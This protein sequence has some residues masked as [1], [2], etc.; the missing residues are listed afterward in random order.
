MNLS[1]RWILQL[2][3]CVLLLQAQSISQALSPVEQRYEQLYDRLGYL[4][5]MRE[6]SFEV[7]RENQA[8]RDSVLPDWASRP[9]RGN[10][11]AVSADA[12][13]QETVA[14]ITFAEQN[15][16]E[17][18]DYFS[19]AIGAKVSKALNKPVGKLAPE[20]EMS[21]ER[22]LLLQRIEAALSYG[23][24][25]ASLQETINNSLMATQ[26][27]VRSPGMRPSELSAGML[28]V[29][30]ASPGV[31]DHYTRSAI[32]QM[33]SEVSD[34]EIRDFLG[35][36]ESEGGRR[37]L[38]S[39]SMAPAMAVAHSW[40]SS[41]RAVAAAVAAVNPSTPSRSTGSYAVPVG[42]GPG[43]AMLLPPEYQGLD[44]EDPRIPMKYRQAARQ[45]AQHASKQVDVEALVAQANALLL[46]GGASARDL[47]S[48]QEELQ[49]A[50]LTRP[51]EVELLVVLGRLQTRSSEKRLPRGSRKWLVDPDLIQQAG[52]TLERAVAA[53]PEHINA[54][55]A[56]GRVRFLLGDLQAAE[57]LFDKAELAGGAGNAWLVL[58]RADLAHERGELAVA[59]K[60]HGSVLE[61]PDADQNWRMLAFYSL[62][63]G[64][65]RKES[66][67]TIAPMLEHYLNEHPGSPIMRAWYADAILRV[68]E[69]PA[70]ARKQ[71]EAMGAE[72]DIGYARKTLA[73]ALVAQAYLIPLSP[74]RMLS[75][76][77]ERLI[78]LS[79]KYDDPFDTAAALAEHPRWSAALVTMYLAGIDVSELGTGWSGIQT[80]LGHGNYDVVRELI[81]LGVNVNRASPAPLLHW[82]IHAKQADLVRALLAKGA[83]PTMRDGYGRTAWEAIENDGTD[84][85]RAISEA[86]G[87]ERK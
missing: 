60:L 79:S 63:L 29:V 25:R 4:Q 44:P 3:L 7:H 26:F 84:A 14:Q 47:I 11:E 77:A 13:V 73:A 28:A 32:A 46:S 1:S 35:F 69:D 38:R 62:A 36:A 68:A 72:G 67:A 54:L 31:A 10:F 33:F 2:L 24:M 22:L 45:A 55:I 76:E 64:D 52:A 85:A 8:A 59:A 81:D 83:D 78:A 30:P 87:P 43:V 53:G 16:Q 74:E 27:L 65:A 9:D 48:M 51:R 71:I 39:A 18:E 42:P 80:A 70:A 86:L 61:D 15:V 75:A 82:A 12:G 5:L 58:S 6:A 41:S 57:A 17:A 23:S 20:V 49:T 40:T 50:L 21:A 19:T 56:L 66:W 34:D 37:L